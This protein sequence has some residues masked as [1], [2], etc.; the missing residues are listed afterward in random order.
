MK[1]GMLAAEAVFDLMSGDA[2][3][4]E[5]ASYA[6][7]IET[8]WLWS[9]LYKVRNIRPAFSKG[10]WVGMGYAA[11]DTYVFRGKAPVD[12]S[13]PFRSHLS[14]AGF[15]SCSNQLPQTRQ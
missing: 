12:I 7:K 8:S 11:I 14:E 9:E 2:T 15:R 5:P 6:K 1:S 13:S 3:G 4:K 10:L